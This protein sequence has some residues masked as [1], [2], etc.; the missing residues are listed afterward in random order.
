MPLL[1]HLGMLVEKLGAKPKEGSPKDETEARLSAAKGEP[2]LVVAHPDHCYR[3]V[4]TLEGEKFTRVLAAQHA[5]PFDAGK[6]YDASSGQ[7]WTRTRHLYLL[8]DKIV[9]V[10]EDARCTWTCRTSITARA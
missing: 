3:C 9:D 6:W 4:R 2:I 5:R 10:K 8:H 7:L 1:A